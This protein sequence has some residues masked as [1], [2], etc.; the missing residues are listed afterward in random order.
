MT[1]ASRAQT[2]HLVVNA[3]SLVDTTPF[4]GKMTNGYETGSFDG[5]A[6]TVTV[7]NK[8]LTIS[9]GAG[10]LDPKINFIEIGAIG[11]SID[12]ATTTRVAAAAVQAT[13]D[14]AR[15]KAKMLN[16]STQSGSELRIIP[17]ENRR[18]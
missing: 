8:L 12:A 11:S 9:A 16:E 2:N 17:R 13:K 3:V 7:T 15:V 4:D 14:T 5:Y 18:S 10:A 1:V 6:L